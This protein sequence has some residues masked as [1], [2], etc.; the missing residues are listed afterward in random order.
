MPFENIRFEQ[1]DGVA[2]IT[3][4]RPAVLNA[5]SM[6][7]MA[8]LDDAITQ[9]DA[10]DEVR[11]VVVTGAGEKAFSAGADIHEMAGMAQ[12]ELDRRQAKRGEYTWHLATC[13][14]PVIGALNG[15]TYG[16]AA[17]LAST[18]DIRVGCERTK[19][20]FLA[21]TY[22]R[23]NSTWT[24]PTLI[25]MPMAK[26]LLYSGRVVE[27]GEAK[28]IG[29]LNRLV[30]SGEL[31]STA[32]ELAA[33]IAKNTPAMVQGIKEL[34]DEGIGASWQERLQMERDILSGRL[35]PAHPREGF[36]EFLERKPR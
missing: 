27:A 8:E 34:L 18:F 3:L 13:R 25:G 1:A 15:L 19:F 5:L 26:E 2:M 12:D 32:R 11:A 22:G 21:A 28:A 23:I 29:L 30:P 6:P 7:L 33:L 35:K 36:K 24:L 31:L 20:R 14:K 9:C 4:N 10:D 16:G 17:V